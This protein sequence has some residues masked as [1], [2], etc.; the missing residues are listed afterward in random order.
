MKPIY[1]ATVALEKNRWEADHIPTFNV[2]DFLPKAKQDGFYGIELWEYHYTKASDEEKS[3]LASFDIPYYFNTYLSLV[4]YDET[5]Y[6]QIADA[7]K[8]LNAKG[9]KFNFGPSYG[10]TPDIP[11]QIE[12]AKRLAD[13]MPADAKL[14]CECHPN[15]V[16]EVPETA[17]EV[18]E[19]LDKER[20]GAIIHMSTKKDF[21]DRCFDAYGDRISHIHC[22]YRG[23]EM[24]G[25]FR[26]MDDGTGYVADMMDYFDGKGFNGSLSVEF[27]KFEDTAEAHYPHAVDA[28]NFLKKVCK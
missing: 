25:D 16:L 10:C 24:D 18:F 20:F 19:Q 13:M 11:K 5:A 26:D 4:E 22:A 28:L 3:K 23:P 8:A 21:V 2:S 17:G 6:K 15:T 14:L 9:V 12:N 7:V 1:L 27:I